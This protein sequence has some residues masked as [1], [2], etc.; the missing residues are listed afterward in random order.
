MK[1]L[2][3]VFVYGVWEVLACIGFGLGDIGVGVGKLSRIDGVHSGIPQLGKRT[4]DDIMGS[5]ID[6]RG[7][8]CAI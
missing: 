1:D 5:G 6:N 3:D 7:E 2:G 8:E 4:I